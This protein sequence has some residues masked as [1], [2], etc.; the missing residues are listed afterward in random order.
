MTHIMSLNSR[1]SCLMRIS[2]FVFDKYWQAVF[3]LV[4]INISP[5]FKKLLQAKTI[6]AEKNKSDYQ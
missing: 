2:V 1:I 3:D 5:T 4:D 6:S